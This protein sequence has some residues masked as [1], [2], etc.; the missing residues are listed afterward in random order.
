MGRKRRS[1]AAVILAS[2]KFRHPRPKIPS[3]FGILRGD[4]KITNS[5]LGQV[6]QTTIPFKKYFALSESFVFINL[7]VLSKQY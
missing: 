3:E 1:A 2:P 4:A 7:I 5:R 6:K